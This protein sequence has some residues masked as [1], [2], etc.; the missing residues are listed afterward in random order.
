MK[1]YP[2][3]VILKAGCGP[4]PLILHKHPETQHITLT[5][6]DTLQHLATPCNTTTA[7]TDTTPDN[8][9]VKLQQHHTSTKTPTPGDTNTSFTNPTPQTAE[10][11]PS[12]SATSSST[13]HT[14]KHSPGS[15]TNHHN[16]PPQSQHKCE[17]TLPTYSPPSTIPHS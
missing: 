12:S 3:L 5:Q 2:F 13:T 11:S 17:H 8:H 16:K 10:S 15:N 6:I 4:R 14:Q 7:N 9:A 1:R